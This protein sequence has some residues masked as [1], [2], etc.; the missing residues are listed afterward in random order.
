MDLKKLSYL[1]RLTF[2]ATL[3]REIF[4]PKVVQ[5]ESA[6]IKL[7]ERCNSRC[8]MCDYWEGQQTDMINTERA[9]NLLDELDRLGVNNLGFTGGEPLLRQD[10]FRILQTQPPGRFRSVGLTTNGLLLGKYSELVNESIVTD[11]VVSLDGIKNT[12]DVI[13]GI[14]GYFDKVISNL[15]KIRNKDIKIASMLTNKFIPELKEMILLCHASGYRLSINIPS[16]HLPFFKSDRV[17]RAIKE[18]TPT[19]K[20][21][22]QALDILQKYEALDSLSIQKIKEYMTLG[23]FPCRHC[24]LGFVSITILSS[25]EVKT[26]CYLFKPVGNIL[27]L[28]LPEIVESSRYAADA[29]RAYKLSCPRCLCGY[30]VSVGFEHPFRS[31][32]KILKYFRPKPRTVQQNMGMPD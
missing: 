28:P 17:A 6:S 9:I 27:E 30:E 21:V 16:T 10:F 20:E 12:N 19:P 23:K 15:K 24:M 31:L 22:Y 7:T 4:L 29:K 14:P 11:I 5:T 8:V 2:S 18:L 1:A 13:R 32:R 3:N 25:G 26:G